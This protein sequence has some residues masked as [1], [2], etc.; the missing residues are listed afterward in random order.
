MQSRR[1]LPRYAFSSFKPGRIE[2]AYRYRCF[3]AH[4]RQE[5]QTQ[6][7]QQ[8][9]RN[10][11]IRPQVWEWIRTWSGRDRLRYWVNLS[12]I[13]WPTRFSL[14]YTEIQP[15]WSIRSDPWDLW[16]RSSKSDKEGLG[17]E[18]GG[19]DWWC[20]ERYRY[21]KHMVCTGYSIFSIFVVYADWAV[22]WQV[23]SRCVVSIRS[24]LHYVGVTSIWYFWTWIDLFPI[25]IKAIEEGTFGE[26]YSLQE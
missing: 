7:W 16:W 23:I 15:W 14:T 1:I 26:R 11:R 12:S 6:E 4:Y 5:N 22:F 2:T 8:N 10:N 18:F 19:W 3:T 9:I 20:L 21:S 24:T 13:P 17:N 25:E